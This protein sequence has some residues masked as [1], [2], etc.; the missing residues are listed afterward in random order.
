MEKVVYRN[1]QYIFINGFYLVFVFT[2]F[3]FFKVSKSVNNT[4]TCQQLHVWSSN[5]MK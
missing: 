3:S 5:F 1:R 4:L 2:A